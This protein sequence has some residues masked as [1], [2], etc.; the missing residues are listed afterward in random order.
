MA[1][2]TVQRPAPALT[3]LSMRYQLLNSLNYHPIYNHPQITKC[4]TCISLCLQYAFHTPW[5]YSK[6]KWALLNLQLK[7]KSTIPFLLP[8]SSLKK[9]FC[10][11]SVLHFSP[12][13]THAVCSSTS[14]NFPHTPKLFLAFFLSA[15][16]FSLLNLVHFS[17]ESFYFIPIRAR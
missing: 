5:G 16:T 7:F 6:V 3:G 15:F 8:F 2:L 9:S 4:L 11:F 14:G 17:P 12:L 13:T 1:R 10:T